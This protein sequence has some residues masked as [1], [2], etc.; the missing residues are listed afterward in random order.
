MHLFSILLGTSVVL[1]L[2]RAARESDKLGMLVA[3][4]KVTAL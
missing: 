3:S 1:G 2:T 4:D